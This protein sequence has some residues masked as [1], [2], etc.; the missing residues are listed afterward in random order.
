[1]TNGVWRRAISIGSAVGQVPDVLPLHY[2]LYQNYPN[3][4]N[5]STKIGFEIRAGSS[6]K[7]EVFNLLGE[8]V[9]SLLDGPLQ[10]G[11]HQQARN[12]DAREV[13]LLVGSG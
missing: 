9:A 12:R 10:A 8:R 4:F 6:V 3:P 13:D 11:F 1:M 7:L 2:A 5:P